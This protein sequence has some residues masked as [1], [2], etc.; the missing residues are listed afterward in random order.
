MTRLEQRLS[1]LEAR[2]G[3]VIARTT[4]DVSKLSTG[5]L[6]RLKGCGFDL[7]KIS[8]VDLA[9]LESARLDQKW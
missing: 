4:I 8:A 2:Q 7:S 6:L 9:E 5:L 3:P 1:R